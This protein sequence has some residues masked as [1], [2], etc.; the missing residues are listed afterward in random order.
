MI[1]FKVSIIDVIKINY[2]NNLINPKN[3][4]LVIY[5]INPS[6]LA[7]SAVYTNSNKLINY[8]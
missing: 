6:T 5:L 8:Y 3:I 7:H 2:K 1:F 4:F